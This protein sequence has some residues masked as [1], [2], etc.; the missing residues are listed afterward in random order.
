MRDLLLLQKDCSI[1]GCGCTTDNYI[2]TFK[3]YTR[4]KDTSGCETGAR[5]THTRYYTYCTSNNSCPLSIFLETELSDAAPKVIN[6]P[7]TLITNT[8]YE[9]KFTLE[10]FFSYLTGM[11]TRVVILSL[12]SSSMAHIHPRETRHFFRNEA[13]RGALCICSVHSP[14]RDCRREPLSGDELG[15]AGA[16]REASPPPLNEQRAA[17]RARLSFSTLTLVPAKGKT[18][19]LFALR[20]DLESENS[21]VLGSISA[22]S[23]D[24]C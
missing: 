2:S 11:A 17:L 21:I 7:P 23:T 22:P 4:S 9:G 6:E 14:A 18:E 3:S 16:A 15:G 8:F 12:Q 1:C 13:Q 20:F 19:H 10:D 24:N 5:T